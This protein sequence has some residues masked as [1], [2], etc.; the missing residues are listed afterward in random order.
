MAVDT[1]QLRTFVGVATAGSFSA[2]ARA[3]G[4]TQSAVS[5]QVAALEADL[6]VILLRRRPTVEV[7]D[8]GARLLEHAGPLL[9]RLAAARTDVVRAAGAPTERLTVA[10]HPLGTDR[11]A[12]VLAA[13]LADRPRLDVR[14]VAAGNI[15]AT[16]GVARGE[17]DLAVIVGLATA[18][19]PLRRPDV[20]PLQAV[21]IGEEPVCLAL[22]AD[23]PLA[24][25]TGPRLADLVDAGWIDAPALGAALADL[26]VVTG[27]RRFRARLRYDGTDLSGLLALIA[28][29]HGL[30]LLPARG[31]RV[32]ATTVP[33]RGC[34]LAFRTEQVRT[35]RTT[36]A[37]EALAAALGG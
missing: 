7:T 29:G 2:A 16:T 24:G 33:L 30:G 20:G 15:E 6:G 26:R 37:A 4:Y 11:L 13:V 8:A 5:Q 23:H 10:V 35:G 1:Q 21:G 22:S 28:A 31:P 9:L 14:V 3:L 25:S 17:F 19:D 18:G 32:D 12:T 34:E 27:E 36:P